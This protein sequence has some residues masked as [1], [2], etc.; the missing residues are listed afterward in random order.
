M[1]IL[2]KQKTV[3]RLGL[4]GGVLGGKKGFSRVDGTCDDL[5][6]ASILFITTTTTT[7]PFPQGSLFPAQVSRLLRT[8]TKGPSAVLHT[9]PQ[10]SQPVT[11][12]AQL[13]QALG[14]PNSTS[15][16]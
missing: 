2:C 11:L 13:P 1:K 16:F 7:S 8:K 3:S 4:G 12:T 5:A 10:N 15:W 9:A 6:L 14:S